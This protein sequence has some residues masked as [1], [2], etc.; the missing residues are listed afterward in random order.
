MTN[1]AE[2][3]ARAIAWATTLMRPNSPKWEELH[4]D[5]QRTFGALARAAITAHEAALKEAGF[6]IVP[7]EPS[8]SMQNRVDCDE[9]KIGNYRAM[10]DAAPEEKP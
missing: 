3:V 1:K 2:Q 10:I 9:E 4:P 6:V 8:A 7:R 5:V